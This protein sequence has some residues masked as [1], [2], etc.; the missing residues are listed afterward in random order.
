MEI[1]YHLLSDSKVL[2]ALNEHF[3]WNNRQSTHSFTSL[4]HKSLLGAWDVPGTV[5]HLGYNKEHLLSLRGFRLVLRTQ[6]KQ[7]GLVMAW[8]KMRKLVRDDREGRPGANQALD[9]KV[10]WDGL[11]RRRWVLVSVGHEKG[12]IIRP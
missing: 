12:G 7:R 2:T 9:M 1:E 8:L 10:A 4:F 3:A 11:G 5:P 6:S